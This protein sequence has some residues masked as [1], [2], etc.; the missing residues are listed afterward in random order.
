MEILDDVASTS[1]FVAPWS[2]ASHEVM[3]TVPQNQA[4]SD[5]VSTESWLGYPMM[6]IINL[7]TMEVLQV[8]T[9]PPSTWASTIEGYLDDLL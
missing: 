5:Y 4:Y 2:T 3:R 9:W 6:P 1:G 8:D 7:Q